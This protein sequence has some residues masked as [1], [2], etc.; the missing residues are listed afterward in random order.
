MERFDLTKML[1]AVE[2]FRVTHVALTPPVVVMMAKSDVTDG[3][4]LSSLQDVVC[5]G[6][7]L[8]KDVIIA[9]TAKFPTVTLVQV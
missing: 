8:S 5:G 1:R 3:Y 2:E 4:D 9:Y 6:A 7:T